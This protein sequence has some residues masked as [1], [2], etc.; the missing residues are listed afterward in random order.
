MG[1]ISLYQAQD[2]PITP[3][4]TEANGSPVLGAQLLVKASTQ[5]IGNRRYG[6]F[7]LVRRALRS[8]YTSA[9][10]NTSAIE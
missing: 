6:K 9:S 1:K 2:C 8:P 5:A 4:E 10:P 3:R 7:M